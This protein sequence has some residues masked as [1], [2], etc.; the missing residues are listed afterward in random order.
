MSK[1]D[2]SYHMSELDKAILI[3]AIE[4]TKGGGDFPLSGM[5]ANI[6]N[7]K[8][9]GGWVKIIGFDYPNNKIICVMNNMYTDW[10]ERYVKF[11]I[12]E[13]MAISKEPPVPV[14]RGNTKQRRAIENANR[15]L[16]ES[17]VEKKRKMKYPDTLIP[18]DHP[19][20]ITKNWNVDVFPILDI[21]GKYHGDELASVRDIVKIGI[22]EGTVRYYIYG[23][24]NNHPNKLIP[25][26][27]EKWDRKKVMRDNKSG[28]WL[29]GRGMKDA[30]LTDPNNPPF[31]KKSPIINKKTFF[32]WR[33]IWWWYYNRGKRGKHIRNLE[34]LLKNV[35][36]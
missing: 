28:K 21:Y 4:N 5:W 22:P 30:D 2:F 16:A 27:T 23:V 15:I 31:Y 11:E 6:R 1:Y 35:K 24:P 12:R 26:Y 32:K 20:N 13:I 14:K 29:T 25:D 33:K 10:Q 17:L 36:G 34:D 3:E 8:R 9:S 18:P 7:Y 19:L